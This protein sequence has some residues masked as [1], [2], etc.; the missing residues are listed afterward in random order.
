MVID[1]GKRYFHALKLKNNP[2]FQ[3]K[4]ICQCLV[5]DGRI[6]C[7]LT[8]E[9]IHE[10]VVKGD[11]G[12][13]LGAATQVKIHS[14]TND[15]RHFH[16]GDIVVYVNILIRDHLAIIGGEII[17]SLGPYQKVG[18]QPDLTENRKIGCQRAIRGRR[19]ERRGHREVKGRFAQRQAAEIRRLGDDT[20]DAL[21]VSGTG[22]L[23]V[24]DGQSGK[25]AWD[26]S[27]AGAG[28]VA[29]RPRTAR[30]V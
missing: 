9:Y 10:A 28:P 5:V 30:S 2:D 18:S 17:I 12:E 26:V 13:Q 11:P 1:L 19:E 21:L 20:P 7:V 25:V 22:R 3:C 27:A 6:L 24:I 29:G 16:K 4:I 15:Q 23:Y 14:G 8:I